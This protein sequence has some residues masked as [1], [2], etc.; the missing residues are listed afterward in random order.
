M[1]RD[2]FEHREDLGDWEAVLWWPPASGGGPAEIAIRARPGA[3]PEVVARGITT[4]TLRSIPVTRITEEMHRR[5]RKVKD[6]A[7]PSL[8]D[9]ARRIRDAVELE[10]RPGRKGRPDAFFADVAA[11]YAWYVELHYPNPVRMLAEA[12]GLTW[13]AAA[14]WVRLARVKGFLTAAAGGR[15]GGELTDKARALLRQ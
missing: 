11:M 10:P 4:G 12:C 14:R 6:D 3:D 7:G 15:P 2:G 9:M 13:K 8:E 1:K 5:V